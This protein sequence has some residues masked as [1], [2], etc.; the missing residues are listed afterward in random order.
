MNR[1]IKHKKMLSLMSMIF[2]SNLSYSATNNQYGNLVTNVG[3]FLFANLMVISNSIGSKIVSIIGYLVLAL[4]VLDIAY[5][6]LRSKLSNISIINMLGDYTNRILTFGFVTALL[7]IPLPSS[8]QKNGITTLFQWLINI[9]LKVWLSIGS[10][11]FSD[12]AYDS[13][14]AKSNIA[15]KTAIGS[16]YVIEKGDIIPGEILNSIIGIPLNIIS[17]GISKVSSIW[18][19][20]S[21]IIIIIIGIYAL[22]KVVGIL[23][24]YVSAIFEF[25]ILLTLSTFYLP[26]LLY[27][28]TKNSI[29]SK[30]L[31]LFIMQGIKLVVTVGLVGLIVE[32]FS[33]DGFVKSSL[34]II[35][36]I[37]MATGFSIME[38]VINNNNQIASTIMTGGGLGVS[39]G[40]EFFAMANQVAAM[41][42]AGIALGGSA[43]G[44]TV[45]EGF[46]T[47]KENRDSGKSVGESL[48]AAVGKSI[49]RG[50]S[51][52]TTKLKNLGEGFKTIGNT[53]DRVK[54]GDSLAD[55]IKYSKI[56]AKENIA[57]NEADHATRVLHSGSSTITDVTSTLMLMLGGVTG[58]RHLYE[59]SNV[60]NSTYG[61]RGMEKHLNSN[62]EAAN[63]YENINNHNTSESNNNSSNSNKTDKTNNDKG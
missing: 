52:V 40:N 44:G 33:A 39:Q 38:K 43:I 4:F 53:I 36:A 55:A 48:K 41:G 24:V 63:S 23:S 29:G 46:N 60:L 57:K 27:E 22:F 37:I 31:E 28:S 16:T 47:F 5:M 17:L 6:I 49:E 58:N 14:V 2:I 26:F 7:L 54:K 34:G 20:F 62:I 15:I 45:N 9:V 19:L 12:N 32:L 1:L 11:F 13:I 42:A 35:D 10:I 56:K 51:F 59:L 25:V 21:G 61:T 30:P 8:Y 18:G 3:N 50:G